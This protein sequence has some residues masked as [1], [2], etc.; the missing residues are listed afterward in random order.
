MPGCV[1]DNAKDLVKKLSK[2]YDQK[3]IMNY[4]T[5][6]IDEATGKSTS[7]ICKLIIKNLE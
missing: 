7:K 5:K 3:T 6:Y 4:K 2:K 1:F